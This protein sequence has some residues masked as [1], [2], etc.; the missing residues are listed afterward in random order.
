[1]YQGDT[2]RLKC[3]FKTFTG[4][5]VDPV[6]VLLTIYDKQE[7]QIEQ[8]TLDDTNKEDVGVYFYDYIATELD[9]FIFEFSGM[10]QDKPILVRDKVKVKFN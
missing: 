10:Y 4:R 2:I 5:L 8:I 9:E 6:S 1:M 7:E 3:H